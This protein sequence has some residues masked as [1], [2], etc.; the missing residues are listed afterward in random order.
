MMDGNKVTVAAAVIAAFGTII[1]AIGAGT[2]A[3]YS[4]GISANAQRLVAETEASS[5]IQ[6]AKIE[7][8]NSDRQ[9]DIEMVK[10]AL[11]ILGGEISDKTQESRQFAVEL[12]KKY[13]GVPLSSSVGEKWATSGSV[14]FADEIAGLSSSIDAAIAA[15]QVINAL[16]NFPESRDAPR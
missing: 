7:K 14:K 13:S 16:K 8:Q 4:A 9:S 2:S 5:K 11:N 10:L 6:I 15:Q 3:Y 1:T 12:L